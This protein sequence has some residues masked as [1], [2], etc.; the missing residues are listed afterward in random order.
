MSVPIAV[1]ALICIAACATGTGTVP[2]TTA[3]RDSTRTQASLAGKGS[4][5]QD[6]ISLRLQFR[7]VSVRMF[8]LDESVI[9]LLAPDSY[10]S[11]RDVLAAHRD[12]IERLRM[13]T[14]SER[15][16]IWYVSFSALEPDV[17]FSPSEVVITSSGRDFRAEIIPLTPGFGEQRIQQGQS[18]TALFLFDAS[19]DVNQP[20]EVSM[21]GVRNAEWASILRVLERE[22]SRLR[23]GR[24]DTLAAFVHF[25]HSVEQTSPRRRPG[26]NPFSF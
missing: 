14:G 22:R 7:G 4:L 20:L 18:Q 1:V 21:E 11:M 16:S 15:F 12:R 5:R 23:S 19:V 25:R 24:V 9:E 8:P 13:S 3:A 2:A 6:A 26:R 17:R 10:K